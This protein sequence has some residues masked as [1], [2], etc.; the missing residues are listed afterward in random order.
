MTHSPEEAKSLLRLFFRDMNLWGLRAIK[1]F[2]PESQDANEVQQEL[3]RELKLIYSKYV[4]SRIRKTGRVE[5]M[6]ISLGQPEY[7]PA[8]EAIEKIQETKS[9]YEVPTKKNY[10]DEGYFGTIG[11]RINLPRSKL[12]G[13]RRFASQ[14]HGAVA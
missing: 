6:T 12:R 4:T 3:N 9:G 8:S 2:K 10:S 5:A 7:D 1:M 11:V 13:I 14:R